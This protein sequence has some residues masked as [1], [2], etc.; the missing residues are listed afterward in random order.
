M[1]LYK[2]KQTNKGMYSMEHEPKTLHTIRLLA[3][4]VQID[5]NIYSSDHDFGEDKDDDDPLE[6][7]ALRNVSTFKARM[8]V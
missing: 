1:Q 6:E 4:G 7:F 2:K 5:N 8:G 3:R